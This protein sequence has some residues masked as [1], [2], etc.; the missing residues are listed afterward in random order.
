MAAKKRRA[1]KPAK[2]AKAKS[3]KRPTI[4]A[5]DNPVI[6]RTSFGDAAAWKKL[7]EIVARPVDDGFLANVD[8][9]DDPAFDGVT[10]DELLELIG[11]KYDHAFIVMADGITMSGKDHTVLVVDLDEKRGSAFRALPSQMQS[12]ENNLSLANMDFAEFAENVGRGGV[13]RGF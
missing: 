1:A 9:L 8:Y 12:I 10:K 4:A 13:F 7:R 6:V 11:K 5:S 2:A 3:S